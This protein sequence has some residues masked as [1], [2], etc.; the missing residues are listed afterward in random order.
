MRACV[1][2]CVRLNGGLVVLPYAFFTKPHVCEEVAVFL[3]SGNFLTWPCVLTRVVHILSSTGP[4]TI[5]GQE[6]GDLTCPSCFLPNLLFFYS[7]LPLPFVLQDLDPYQ[8]KETDAFTAGKTMDKYISRAEVEALADF[9]NPQ[10][11]T[12][13]VSGG[14]LG[15]VSP[16]VVGFCV[17]GWVGAELEALAD[18]RNPQF[19]TNSVSG[20]C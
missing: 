6:G 3:C 9:R 20:G 7:S 5:P 19:L 17:R 11:L 13:F 1:R 14:C 18:F 2:A 15:V 10:F 16:V 12:S 8:A 4:V